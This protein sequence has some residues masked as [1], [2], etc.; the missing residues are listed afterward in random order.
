[1]NV[2]GG[3]FNFDNRTSSQ[4]ISVPDLRLGFIY[5]RTDYMG[6]II[7]L[8]TSNPDHLSWTNETLGNGSQ[9]IEM[10][11][12]DSDAI[13]YIPVEDEGIL[14]TFRGGNICDYSISQNLL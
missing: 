11:N 8:N 13:I 6:G 5:S 4:Y 10:P 1:M 14:I 3:N 7:Q 12:L 2:T 9:G